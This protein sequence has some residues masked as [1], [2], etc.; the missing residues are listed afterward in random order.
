MRRAGF[1][2]WSRVLFGQTWRFVIVGT[3]GFIVDAGLLVVLMATAGLGHYAGRV[4]SFLVA[5][6][7]TWWL[8]RTF[9]FRAA[10]L[11][12]ARHRA[13]LVKELSSY[14]LFQSVGITI[15]FAVYSLLIERYAFFFENPA[16]AVA[17]GSLVAMFFNFAT[18]RWIVFRSRPAERQRSA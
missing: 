16:L 3:I 17:A 8:N 13:S 1:R 11:S 6:C 12:G 18:A 9:T 15:N 14:V 4:L 7:V 2:R 10:A 5:V